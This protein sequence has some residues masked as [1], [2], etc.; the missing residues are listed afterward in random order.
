MGGPTDSEFE[1][2]KNL[3]NPQ[4][5]NFDKSSVVLRA[6]QEE[7]EQ[8]SS[9]PPS[10]VWSLPSVTSPRRQPSEYSE[11]RRPLS[12]A[13]VAPK[14]PIEE[15]EVDDVAEK[16]ALLV[17]LNSLSMKGV[18]LSRQFTMNDPIGD[19][20]FE[21]NRLQSDM[22]AND[23]AVIA[24]D[25]MIMGLRGVELANNKWGPILHLDG[26]ADNARA[27]N[28][29]YKNVF[30]RLYKK[31]VRK[32]GAASPEITLLGLL[33]GSALMTHLDHVG[34][35]QTAKVL[36]QATSGMGKRA[37]GAFAQRPSFGT[38]ETPRP[39]MPQPGHRP[40]MPKP[41]QR[42]A[43]PKPGQK[44]SP[45]PPRGPSPAELENAKLKEE[46]NA[47]KTHL[48]QAATST[49]VETVTFVNATEE[50]RKSPIIEVI[51]D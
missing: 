22:M 35:G 27:K 21:L 10:P 6:L 15:E 11:P 4:C 9:P 16:Q 29:A 48:H 2:F 7:I 20:T 42:P 24:T 1:I 31:Y 34:G 12:V 41:G 37:Q 28:D 46:L 49:R 43:M 30:T 36:L 23:A 32:P 26:W 45:P 40:D 50:P 8:P 25:A 19:M 5:T 13:S 3:S 39:D 47:L 38:H 14:Q 18:K 51:N 33:G 17:E 44:T